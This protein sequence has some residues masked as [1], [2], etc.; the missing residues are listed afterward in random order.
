MDT[1]LNSW[2]GGERGIALLRFVLDVSLRVSLLCLLAGAVTLALRKS[3][4]YARKMIWVFTLVG[5]MLLPS[6]AFLNP[7]W[8][9]SIIPNLERWGGVFGQQGTEKIL[10]FGDTGA[11]TDMRAAGTSV[12]TGDSAVLSWLRSGW[13]SLVFLAWAVGASALLVWLLLTGLLVRRALRDAEPVDRSWYRLE[14][15]LRARIG[16]R[17][18]VPLLKSDRTSTAVTTGVFYPIVILPMDADSWSA[19]RRRL[20]LSHELAH[21]KRKDGLIELLASMAL[22]LH[23]FNPLV[24]MAAARFRIERERDCDNAV[25]NEGVRPSEYAS[26]LLDIAADVSGL[27]RPVWRLSTISQSSHLK[28]RL[29]CI[30]NPTVDRTTGNRR[31]VMKAVALILAVIIPLSLL[32]V[33]DT[34]AEEKKAPPPSKEEK[35]EK[36]SKVWQ[37]IATKEGSAAAMIAEVIDEKGIEIGM[38]KCQALK[39]KKSEKYYFDEKEFNALGYRYLYSG[40]YDKAIGVFKLN[41]KNYPDSWNAYDSLGEAYAHKGELEKAKKYYTKSLEMNPENENGKKMLQKIEYKMQGGEE[42]VEKKVQKKS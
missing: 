39:E 16:L 10:T 11:A 31:C 12:G 8:N 41:V 28:N 18:A 5:I 20:V 40:D 36:I 42:K 19:A 30:L 15:D 23:W 21:V 32:G 13:A 2:F 25:L 38:K 14:S 35:G 33:W 1:F 37:E 24:W 29:L 22:V 9:V 26:L 4:A 17:H 3:S 34:R 27:G 6:L 7:V